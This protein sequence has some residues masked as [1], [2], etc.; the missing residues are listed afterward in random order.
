MAAPA[1]LT[2]V[3]ASSRRQTRVRT[4][5][6]T[7]PNLLRV[8]GAVL[9]A[10]VIVVGAVALR[11]TTDRR[12]AT[13][14]VEFTATPRLVAAED[15][16]VKLADA[17]ATASSAFLQGSV[18]PVGLRQRY[19]ADIHDAAQ[20]L[21]ALAA[22]SGASP[23]AQQALAD[24]ARALPVYT[25]LVEAARADNRQGSLL[26]AAYLRSASAL[27]R[28]TILPSTTTVYE[29]AARQVDAGYRAGTAPGALVAVVATT[30]VLL[31]LLVVTQVALARRT[32]RVLNV[33]LVLAT[34]LVLT[35]GAWSIGALVAQ[36]NALTRSQREGSDALQILSTAR[37][38]TLRSFSDENL[39]LIQRG[40]TPEYI[41]DF[42]RVQHELQ[43]GTG[44]L[45]AAR[46]IA[47]RNG[48]TAPVD[49]LIRDNARYLDDHTA[50]QQR[51]NT[52]GDYLGAVK[53]ATGTEVADFSM[54]DNAYRRD[55]GTAGA[56][57]T[58]HAAT[59]RDALGGLAIGAVILAIL[60]AACTVLGLRRRI[61]EYS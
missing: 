41:P 36:Q 30:G 43:G 55:V 32:R 33:G 28:A 8:A 50:W 17:D 57:L 26:G 5:R 47:A 39:E 22:G 53:V 20:Q 60:A 35:I 15:A 38:L 34:V 19:D 2:Q 48:S 46:S 7:T 31:I 23:A 59:A 37:I 18:E 44:L 12:D 16:Y 51:A 21:T 42:D 1:A 25:G 9:A 6:L 61:Q 40:A 4:A 14:Q 3:P 49:T 56:R 29:D 11:S 10:G 45:A 27:M 24:A 13:R 58:A 52:D 54:L